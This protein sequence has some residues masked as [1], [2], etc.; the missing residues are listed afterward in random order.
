MHTAAQALIDRSF[1]VTQQHGQL[2]AS[3]LGPPI[4]STLHPSAVLRAPDADA[5]EQMYAQL[6]DDLRAIAAVA[7]RG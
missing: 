6:V 5:R 1:R 3:Q 4:G 7:R 2:Q